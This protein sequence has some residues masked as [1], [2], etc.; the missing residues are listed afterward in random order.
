MDAENG[1]AGMVAGICYLILL[2][3]FKVEELQLL[4]GLIKR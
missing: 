4:K 1:M 2:L 3:V